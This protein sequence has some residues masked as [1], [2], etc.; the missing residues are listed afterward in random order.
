MTSV[1]ISGQGQ[2][3]FHYDA[4]GQRIATVLP[5]GQKIFTP[6]PEYEEEV[7]T[8]GATTERSNYFLNG[9][10]IAM[11]VAVTGG[12]DTLY[13][14]YADH[15]GNVSALTNGSTFVNGSL[16]R[17]E[18]Y[19]GF[20][21]QPTSNPGIT[22]RGFTGHSSNNTG[23]NDLDL[24]YMNA[25]YYLPEIGRFMSALLFSDIPAATPHVLR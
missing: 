19:G 17:Y 22:D 4:N 6:F 1:Q 11:R 24:I 25:R 9:Q 8:S 10:L 21:T 16:A 18:P 5:G 20:R 23:T 15:L 14:T 7:P 12:S 2:T 3:I 13:F